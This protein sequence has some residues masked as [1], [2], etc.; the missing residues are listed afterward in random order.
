MHPLHPR[1]LAALC[2]GVLLFTLPACDSDDPTDEPGG[3]SLAEAQ[4]NPGTWFFVETP[5]A[6]CRDGSATGFG[7]RL[8]EGASNLMIYL[9]GG[10]AC[11]STGT[12]GTN[13]ASFGA[14]DFDGFVA[15]GGNAGV[16]STE[17][18]NP[19]GDWNMVYV[20]YCTGDVHGGRAPAAV[21]PNVSGLQQFVGHRNVERYLDVLAPALD[22]DNVLLAGSSAGGFGTLIN[23]EQVADAFDGSAAYMLDDSGPLFFADNVFS[24]G[25]ASGL[26]GLY[27]LRASLPDADADAL[28][29]NDGL[30]GIY[31]YYD[32]RYPDATFG[33]SSYTGDDVIRRFFAPG[34]P[35]QMITAEEYEAGL[36]DVRT[37]LPDSWGTY[38]VSGEE[39]TFLRFPDRY[40][41]S[42]DGTAY[43]EWLTQLLN[44]NPTDVGPAT[45]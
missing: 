34:Q 43:T 32:T 42:V 3:A 13:P 10:G 9:E 38:Y 19:V 36:S 7:V 18:A 4:A 5:G 23:F 33:L 21:V 40:F 6:E 14:A 2:L 28:F 8:Q 35:D 12:C 39:H 15:Q 37:Q 1:L 22:P 20:P 30:P 44:G 31:A 41:G 27:N 17:S 45:P 11:F 29:E 26:A 25:L 16:F 24:P